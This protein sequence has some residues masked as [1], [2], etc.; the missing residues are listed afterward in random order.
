MEIWVWLILQ[1]VFLCTERLLSATHHYEG[2]RVA[3]H[4][5]ISEISPID[6]ID[7]N[8]AFSDLRQARLQHLLVANLLEELNDFLIESV[9]V[10]Q[11]FPEFISL[12]LGQDSVHF[13]V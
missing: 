5:F 3:E 2:I 1:V 13:K 12:F 8:I 6:H 11:N 4:V 9:D 10:S 7:S